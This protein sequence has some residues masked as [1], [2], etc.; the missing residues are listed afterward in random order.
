MVIPLLIDDLQLV[1]KLS[2]ASLSQQPGFIVLVKVLNAACA[3]ATKDAIQL[4]PIDEG[5]DRKIKAL[6]TRARDFNEFSSL[7]LDSI[8]YHVK[9]GKN[10]EVRKVEASEDN[11][12]NRFANSKG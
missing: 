11:T 1:E 3:K 8:A 6:H 5:Y 2:L 4:N 10:R 7:V 12:V 9:D